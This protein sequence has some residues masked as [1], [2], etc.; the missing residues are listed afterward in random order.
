MTGPHGFFQLDEQHAGDVRVRRDRH[1]TGRGAAHAGRAG[2]PAASR[3]SGWSTGACAARTTCSWPDEAAAA[4]AAAGAELHTYL[5][6][7]SA[8]WGGPRGRIT[9]PILDR[10]PGLH[11]P[12]FYLVG[13]G[14]MIEELKKA[15]V[16]RGVDRKRQIRTEAFFD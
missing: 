1:R 14:A 7:P 10:Y 9:A 15:L 13:N 3:A 5:S 6:R 11:A 2:G 4:C 12:T 16:A 8:A